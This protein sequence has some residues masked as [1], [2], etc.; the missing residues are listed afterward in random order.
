MTKQEL[1][2][3]ISRLKQSMRKTRK[4]YF[5][6]E[7]GVPEPKSGSKAF[8]ERAAARR[9]AI[10]D[11]EKHGDMRVRTAYKTAKSATRAKN[12][13]IGGD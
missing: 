6:E 7:W 11:R 13:V 12:K 3:A 5:E 9:D 2:V 1:I 8:G 4:R 10:K